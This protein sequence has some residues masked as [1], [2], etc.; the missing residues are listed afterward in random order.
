MD[1]YLTHAQFIIFKLVFA[2][3]TIFFNR[4]TYLLFEN[5]LTFFADHAL[6]LKVHSKEVWGETNAS[7]VLTLLPSIPS[8]TS[9]ACTLDVWGIFAERTNAE[10]QQVICSTKSMRVSEISQK[11]KT[12]KT[13]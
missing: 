12:D 7:I 2:L 4:N 6:P 3:C 10:R 5:Y 8:N 1:V 9:L 13:P 11:P